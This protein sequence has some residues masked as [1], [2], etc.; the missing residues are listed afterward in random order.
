M[1][2]DREAVYHKLLY[3]TLYSIFALRKHYVSIEKS[4]LKMIKLIGEWC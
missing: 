1:C 4:L 3:F 2:T